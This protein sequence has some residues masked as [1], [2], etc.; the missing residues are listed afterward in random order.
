[1]RNEPPHLAALR[2]L[3]LISNDDIEQIFP[4]CRDRDNVS[5]W[6]CRR[7]GVIFLPTATHITDQY[8]AR[9][10]T[11]SYYQTSSRSS[12]LQLCVEDDMRRAE[13]FIDLSRNAAWID[14]GTGLGG[15]LD[16]LR[17]H[18]SEVV[19]VEPQEGL[20]R[21]ALEAGHSILPSIV[22]AEDSHFDVASL[23]HVLEHLP[24]PIAV[25][26]D[27]RRCMKPGGHLI[28]EIPHARDFLLSFLDLEEF[29]RHTFWSEHLILHTRRSLEAF[30]TASQ[31]SVKAINGFQRYPLAN[32]LFWLNKGRPGG[33]KEWSFLRSDLLDTA[34]AAKLNELDMTDTLIAIATKT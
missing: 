20:R 19:G 7:S 2:S 27:V 14:V 6:R 29:K 11:Q 22:E 21:L 1:M 34:Y 9:G 3:G 16:Y 17:P 31:F 4:R 5:V 26:K 24:D 32:H 18:C 8:Y 25:L 10:D 33:H 13:Q 30:L 12:A 15:L 23:F 28:V